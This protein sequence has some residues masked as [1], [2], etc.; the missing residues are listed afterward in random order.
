MELFKMSHAQK[1][2]SQYY[3]TTYI[4]GEVSASIPNGVELTD[5]ANRHAFNTHFGEQTTALRIDKIANTFQYNL[6]S[7]DVTVSG[8]FGGGA[9]QSGSRAHITSSINPTGLGQIRSVENVSY[10]AGH[11][12]YTFFTAE[13]DANSANNIQSIGLFDNN[14]GLYV[15]LSSSQFAAVRRKNSN[16][17]IVSQ[18]DFNIDTIDGSGSSGF[19]L[20]IT[21]MNIFNIS[22]GW[23]GASPIIF[24]VMGENGTWIPFHHILVSNV[25]SE[26]SIGNPVL[27]LTAKVEKSAGADNII[28]KT[29]SWNGGL[30]GNSTV[31]TVSARD[32]TYYTTGSINANTLTNIFT[33]RNKSTFQDVVNKIRLNFM[34]HGAASDGTKIVNFFMIRNVVLTGSLFSNID[35]ENSVVEVD[36]TATFA[37]GQGDIV[38]VQPIGKVDSEF[39]NLIDFDIH[40]HSPLETMTFAAKSVGTSDITI[41]TRWR[42]TF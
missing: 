34:F 3:N 22:F 24:Q 28:L 12:M 19:N 31:D 7:H 8:A 33:I 36:T 39:V 6:A 35:E 32:F 13:F 15:M 11:E 14:D 9:F 21:K 37:E 41:S 17:N 20:D 25:L 26:T 10:V 2:R 16:N 1:S 5:S 18:S 38:L 29:A 23:L 27:P 40:L 30:Y 42:E 4:E